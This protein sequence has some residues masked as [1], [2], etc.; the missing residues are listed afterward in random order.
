MLSEEAIE[1][2]RSLRLLN[3][4]EMLANIE[5]VALQTNC[6]QEDILLLRRELLDKKRIVEAKIKASSPLDDEEKDLIRMVEEG[7]YDDDNDC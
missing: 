3:L 5:S 4:N 1:E 6:K 2:F 7:E